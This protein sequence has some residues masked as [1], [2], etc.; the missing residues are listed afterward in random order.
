LWGII[1]NPKLI[2][3]IQ[4]DSQGNEFIHLMIITK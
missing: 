3:K 4:S 1:I 2:K